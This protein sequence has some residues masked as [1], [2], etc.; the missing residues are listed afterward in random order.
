MRGGLV[1]CFY[2]GTIVLAALRCT[3]LPRDGHWKHPTAHQWRWEV[4]TFLQSPRVA[5]FLVRLG[6]SHCGDAIVIDRRLWDGLGL[7]LVA[8]E[9][10]DILCH[11]SLCLTSLQV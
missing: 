3:C 10:V 8:A 9:H 11:S 4:I 2:C 1:G 5:P 6:S 7:L